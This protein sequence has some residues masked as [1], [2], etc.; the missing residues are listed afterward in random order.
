MVQGANQAETEH[1]QQADLK[2]AVRVHKRRL[3]HVLPLFGFSAKLDPS[4]LDSAL[5]PPPL[6][7]SEAKMCSTLFKTLAGTK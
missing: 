1:C 7:V 2:R 6:T 3:V 4:L 5:S